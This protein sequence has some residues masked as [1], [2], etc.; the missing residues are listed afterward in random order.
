MTKSL[1]LCFLLIAR[2]HLRV[3]AAEEH[4]ENS[5]TDLSGSF[6]LTYESQSV[7]EASEVLLV[8]SALRYSRLSFPVFVTFL[9]LFHVQ[10]VL[11]CK[12][13]FTFSEVEE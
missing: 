3:N 11:G 9:L 7:K 12:A 2:I 10:L 5:R 13:C 8:S 4:R 1:L 6:S